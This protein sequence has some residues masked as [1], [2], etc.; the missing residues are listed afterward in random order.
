MAATSLINP[1]IYSGMT[2]QVSIP[3]ERLLPDSVW[4]ETK[5]EI[6]ELT[7]DVHLETYDLM[8]KVITLWKK[9]KGVTHYFI[10]AKNE[11]GV[12]NKFRWEVMPYPEMSA[13]KTMY[14]FGLGCTLLFRA[15]FGGYVVSEQERTRDYSFYDL[16]KHNFSEPLQKEIEKT[17]DLPRKD[18]LCNKDQRE[19][20][21]VFEGK[22]INVYCDYAPLGVP[23][24]QGEPIV[25]LLLAP[26]EH[27]ESF[28]SLTQE[29]YL[30][31]GLYTN[32]LNNHYTTERNANCHHIFRIGRLLQSVWHHHQHFHANPVTDLGVNVTVV[33]KMLLG[34][35][36]LSPT[37]LETN[38]K[39]LKSD[40]G[41]LL[42]PIRSR[43]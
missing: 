5:P 28:Y 1:V 31:T 9:E 23:L 11:A 2:M 13:F 37:E 41:P 3:T 26:K 15:N 22:H 25:H 4:I 39:R 8:Q 20:Q 35:N 42:E 18:F 43:L 32:A 29:E 36:A 10:L 17:N 16:H 7:D 33:S 30:E 21:L 12:A 24:S 6:T 40:V 14:Y 19:N 38:I 27:K 34:G